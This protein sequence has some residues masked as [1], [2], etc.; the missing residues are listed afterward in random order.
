M[1]RTFNENEKQELQKFLREF[2]DENI[3]WIVFEWFRLELKESKESFLRFLNNKQDLKLLSEYIG[4]E[5][6]NL[7]IEHRTDFI[8]YCRRIHLNIIPQHQLKFLSNDHRLC[9]FIINIHFRNNS[10]L[11]IINSDY[12]FPINPYFLLLFHIYSDNIYTDTNRDNINFEKI[13]EY[14]NKM[15]RDSNPN[16]LLNKY[17]DNEYFP[18]WALEYTKNKLRHYIQFRYHNPSNS[19]QA[20]ELL[21]I[22]WDLQYYDNY[23]KYILGIQKLKKAWQQK[24]FRDKGGLKK[25]YHLPLTK[26]TKSQL[27]GLAEKMN[28]SETKVLEK[29]I[30]DAY[31]NEMLDEKGKALY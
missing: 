28:I 13:I 16:N 21:L 31:Q 17:I 29:L 7:T 9:W 5:L 8:K 14:K 25:Q 18:T 23:D 15:Y 20:L 30:E 2:R 1:L 10:I 4:T 24:Q 6:S 27:V 22:I 11:D 26:K 3:I 19:E 12:E